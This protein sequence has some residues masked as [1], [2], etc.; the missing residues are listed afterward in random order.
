MPSQ[1]QARNLLSKCLELPEYAHWSFTDYFDKVALTGRGHGDVEI[2]CQT[3]V[4]WIK[5]GI[6]G[7]RSNSVWHRKDVEIT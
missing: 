4:Q 3:P 2:C 6:L 5:A 1:T 7:P